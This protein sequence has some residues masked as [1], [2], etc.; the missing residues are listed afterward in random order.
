MRMFRNP[1]PGRCASCEG[2]ITG[3]PIHGSNLEYCCAGC[4][5]GGPC[6][7]SYEADLA[8]D[9]VDHLGLLVTFRPAYAGPAEK[10]EPA[11]RVASEDAP[12]TAARR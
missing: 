9:G 1:R 7:C 4:A 2:E 6:V 11:T 3:R 5:E 10:R 12:A 8:D